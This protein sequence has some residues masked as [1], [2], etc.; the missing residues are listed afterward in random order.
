MTI[1]LAADCD[2][3]IGKS[4]GLLAHIPADMKFFRETTQ[5][6]TVVMGRKTW[7]SFPKKPLPNR[8]NCVISRSVKALDGA[9]VFGSV[10]D[11]LQYAKTAEGKIFVI[12][13]GE[14]Y[15]Q[16]LPYCDEAFITRIYECFDG[17][18]FFKDLEQDKSWELAEASPAVESECRTIRF[19]RYVRKTKP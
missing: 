9:L 12:G 14:I 13:G 4:G 17:D 1:I 7:D 3:A 10:E 6:S 8:V 15:R 2:W 11:F 19:F 18:V 5:N 16:L